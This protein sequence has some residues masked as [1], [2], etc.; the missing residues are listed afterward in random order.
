LAAFVTGHDIDAYAIRQRLE[1][2]LQAYAVPQRICILP[3]LPYNA[4]GKVDRHTLMRLLQAQ[5]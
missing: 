5:G 2:K 4:N 3:Q 1:S